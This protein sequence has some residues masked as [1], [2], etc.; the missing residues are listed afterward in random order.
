VKADGR[1]D[2]WFASPERAYSFEMKRAWL[3]ATPSNLG[4]SLRAAVEDVQCIQREEYHY[5][6]GV[7]VT[8]VRDNEREPTYRAFTESTDVDLA[9]RIGGRCIEGEYLFFKLAC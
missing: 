4:A 6:A 5:A 8:R 2:L 7:L 1:A 9:Y 3:A